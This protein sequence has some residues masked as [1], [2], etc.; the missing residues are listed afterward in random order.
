MD[1][2]REGGTNALLGIRD[3]YIDPSAISQRVDNPIAQNIA[4]AVE[5]PMNA[6][7]ALQG[8]NKEMTSSMEMA[9]LRGNAAWDQTGGLASFLKNP[10][11]FIDRYNELKTN[12]MQ[13]WQQAA[14]AVGQRSALRGDLGGWGKMINQVVK[15]N[16]RGGQSTVGNLA[17]PV[18]RIGWNGAVQKAEKSPIGALGTAWDVGRGLLPVQ[19]GG[20]QLTA[21]GQPLTGFGPYKG[22]QLSELLPALRNELTASGSR[23]NSPFNQPVQSGVTPLAERVKNNVMGTA[24]DLATMA[25]A[26]ALAHRGLD[27]T[28]TGNGPDDTATRDQLSAGG[29]LQNAIHLPGVGYVDAATLM[30]TGGE[31][32]NLV[33]NLMD[34][35]NYPSQ[36]EV[37]NVQAGRAAGV[38]DWIYG[39]ES[40]GG[41]PHANAHAAIDQSAMR[42]V[43]HVGQ[44]LASDA[45]LRQIAT[46]AN[47]LY[48]HTTGAQA[49]NT[50]VGS[51]LGGLV[52]FSGALRSLAQMGDVAQ[53]QPDTIQQTI[54]QNLPGLRGQV[55]ERV[56]PTGQA[57]PNPRAGLGAF[58]PVTTGTAINDPT[59]QVLDQHGVPVPHQDTT[60]TAPT[61]AAQVTMT[62]DEQRMV[63]M[64]RGYLIQQNVRQVTSGAGYQQA[65]R[66]QQGQ[67]LKR[68][69]SMA[70]A[71]AEGEMVSRVRGQ[72]PSRLEPA[73]KIIVTTPQPGPRPQIT[74]P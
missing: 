36:T 42:L 39:L 25:I 66:D 57:E 18:F 71:Q 33:G 44:N 31:T 7:A 22:A 34:A 64:R 55:P 10:G 70:G 23:V 38:P 4:R 29:W 48:G 67:M 1:A 58:S 21:A 24:T 8:F 15:A 13:G 74:T 63:E 45:G 53:R 68:A 32:M 35:V 26:T 51:M 28:I 16:D 59:L 27:G 47:A 40:L 9:R 30:P 72:D 19:R 73:K 5:S 17:W 11:G 65:S 12:P 49:V 41:D 37:R 56:G 61:G 20:G 60:A 14:D 6:H 69:V 62:P 2:L 54:M 3:A 50:T 46:A 43:Q 52:P